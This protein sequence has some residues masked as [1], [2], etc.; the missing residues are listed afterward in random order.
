MEPRAVPPRHGAGNSPGG[1]ATSRGSSIFVESPILSMGVAQ[2]K[3]KGPGFIGSCVGQRCCG[4]GP[5]RCSRGRGRTA[6]PGRKW[7][8]PPHSGFGCVFFATHRPC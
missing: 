5:D 6:I 8:M 3:M 1:L 4:S 2:H 7:E